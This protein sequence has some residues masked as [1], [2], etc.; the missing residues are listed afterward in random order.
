MQT[1]FGVFGGDN[2]TDRMN[3]TTH[4]KEESGEGTKWKLGNEVAPWNS[5]SLFPMVDKQ[6]AKAYAKAIILLWE[7]LPELIKKGT[8][9]VGDVNKI[10]CEDLS[11]Y[12]QE[13]RAEYGDDRDIDGELFLELSQYGVVT[14]ASLGK[15]HLQMEEFEDKQLILTV[16]NQEQSQS[17]LSLLVK[18]LVPT[19][20]N[21]TKSPHVKRCVTM[22]PNPTQ[23]HPVKRLVPQDPTNKISSNEETCSYGA[24]SNIISSY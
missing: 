4:G 14:L 10:L 22:E 9:E 24:Q 2:Y 20:L 7:Q 15:N 13:T 5:Y 3:I 16:S 19:R 12:C 23:S 6:E 8:I 21:P 1:V 17:P 11:K 18:R